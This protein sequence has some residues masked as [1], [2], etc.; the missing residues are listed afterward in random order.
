MD[1]AARRATRTRKTIFSRLLQL[2]AD[3]TEG[4]AEIGAN[5][6]ERGDRRD[7]NQRSNQRDSIAV[8]LRLSSVSRKITSVI[9]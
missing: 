6:S 3:V 5:Q 7:G 4:A 9:A 2:A 8:T 1:T